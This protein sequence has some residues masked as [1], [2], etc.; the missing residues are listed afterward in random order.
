MDPISRRKFLGTA[1]AGGAAAELL[2]AKEKQAAEVSAMT[3]RRTPAPVTPKLFATARSVMEWSVASG[4]SYADPFREIELDAVFA[5]TDGREWRVP[6]FWAGGQTW[7]VRFAPPQPGRY[8]FRTIANDPKNPDLHDRRGEIEVA[9][10]TGDNPLL[11]HGMIRVAANGRTFEHADGT[12]FFWLADT[13]WMGLCKRLRWPQDFQTLATDRVQKGF[14]VVQIIAG[15]YPDMPAFDPRGANEAGQMW[16]ENFARINPHYYDMADARIF[17]LVERGLA[18]CIVGCWGYYLPMMGVEKIQQH[19][20]YLVA[21]WGALPVF[22]CLAGEGLMPYYLSKTP[23]EDVAMQ[24]KGFTDVGRMLRNIDAYRHPITIH[25]SH[26]GADQVEDPSVLDFELLQTG[27]DDRK[28]IPGHVDQVTAEVARTPR[29]PVLVG[30]VCYEGIMEASRQEVQRFMFWSAVLSGAAG[31]TYGAN[32]IW[33]VNTPEQPY[34]PSPHGRS[35]GDTPWQEAYQLPGSKHLGLAKA[36]LMRYEW[37]KFEPH[38]EW[39]EPHWSKQ[40]YARPYAAGIPGKVRVI[41]VPNIWDTLKVVGLESGVKYQA[42]FF[43]PPTGKEYPLGWIT[44]GSSGSW[45]APFTPTVGDWVL[46]LEAV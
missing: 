30:E 44:P 33:Q 23:Q 32:G 40:E 22:W 43:H 42:F 5:D 15:P 8:T 28:A 21:R 29:K 27:H 14:T 9:P 39:V 1:T 17:H 41:F 19:W 10:Y 6:A 12:P 16:E 20:R 37:W 11:K 31:H 26:Q 3:R 4:K 7:R 25:R 35:W 45:E 46:V 13:W 36:L 34:G 38:P 2:S 24:K 18:P